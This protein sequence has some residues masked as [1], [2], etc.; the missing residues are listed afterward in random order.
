MVG[1][2]GQANEILFD[3]TSPEHLEGTILRR[4][5]GFFRENLAEDTDASGE[6]LEST[7]PS[8]AAITSLFAFGR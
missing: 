5:G 7:T 1:R 6:G 8:R 3:A 4:E 2:E